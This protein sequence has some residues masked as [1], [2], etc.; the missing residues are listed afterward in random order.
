MYPVLIRSQISSFHRPSPL[1]GCQLYPNLWRAE[2]IDFF[3]RLYSWRCETAGGLNLS[4]RYS[5]SENEICRLQKDTIT[6]TFLH[7]SIQTQSQ[8][9]FVFVSSFPQEKVVSVNSYNKSSSP[10]HPCTYG[11]FREPT[12][13]L[14]F[15]PWGNCFKLGIMRG[16]TTF[17]TSLE[18]HRSPRF[19]HR[20]SWG[21]P[22]Q[23]GPCRHLRM[24]A[25]EP[26]TGSRTEQ[27]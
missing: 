15:I 13:C 8:Q 14:E 24:T 26:D 7:G 12:I 19:L 9:N 18:N 10:E 1:L 16:H 2:L 21:P 6:L 27:S 17:L 20:A 25:L 4:N 11:C 22:L 3:L 5:C 23:S